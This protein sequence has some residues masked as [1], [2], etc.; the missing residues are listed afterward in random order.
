MHSVSKVIE[1]AWFCRAFEKKLFSLIE[2]KK[3]KYPLYL[4][5]GQELIPATFASLFNYGLLG[6]NR[7]AIFGQHRGHST[8]LCYGGSPV[9]LIKEL[10]GEK[11]GCAYGMGGSASIQSKDIKMFGHDGLMGSQVPIAVGHALSSK[12]FT[13][14]IMGDASAEEDYVMSSIAWAAKKKLP[15]VFIVEDNNLSILTEK[16]V[17]RDWSMVDFAKSVG[18]EA[19]ECGDDPREIEEAFNSMESMPC[20]FNVNTN[21]LWWH[22]GAG[23]DEEKQDTLRNVTEELGLEEL[24]EKTELMNEALWKKFL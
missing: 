13:V 23:I 4:S 14:A 12:K 15:I 6:Q 16:E 3:F 20:L 8:Y 11:D 17:R 9:A 19:Y 18:C 24:E 22:A 21:R 10:L 1:R 5:A 2:E 7:P